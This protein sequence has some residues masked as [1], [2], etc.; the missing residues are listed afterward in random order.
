MRHKTKT[1]RSVHIV[2]YLLS[3]GDY[4][5]AMCG[6]KKQLIKRSPSAYLLNVSV[7]I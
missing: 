2:C 7:I 1:T 3:H 4:K 5:N 6:K